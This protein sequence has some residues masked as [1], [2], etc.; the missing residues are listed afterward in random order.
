[1]FTELGGF[2]DRFFA[3]LDEADLCMKAFLR[4][5]YCY[6]SPE[7]VVY[8]KGSVSFKRTGVGQY[9]YRERNRVWFLYK[10]FPLST[11]LARLVFL[12]VLELRVIRIM[13][14]K[15]RRPDQ[16]VK[17]RRDAFAA[18]YFYRET[19]NNNLKLL[20]KRKKLF[21]AYIKKGLLPPSSE[22]IRS[23]ADG[24]DG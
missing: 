10:Y 5:W 7:S 22:S 16:Y 4:G 23:A 13:C 9:Y 21:W 11:L 3:Y 24:T 1:M 19:R 15:F 17:A 12:V 6:Y 14:V 8:H 20:E 18:L 2:D